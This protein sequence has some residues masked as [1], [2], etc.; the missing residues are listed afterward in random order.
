MIKIY[1][2]ILFLL[3]I[4]ATSLLATNTETEKLL[5]LSCLNNNMD[6]VKELIEKYGEDYT[7]KLYG[8]TILKMMVKNNN[9]NI[10]LVKLLISNKAD[11]NYQ[12]DEEHDTSLHIA[13]S[14]I[15][16]DLVKL[17][18]DNSAN[19]NKEVLQAYGMQ[20]DIEYSSSFP[21]DRV[22]EID[23]LPIHKKRDALEIIKYL[24]LKDGKYSEENY[25]EEELLIEDRQ[26]ILEDVKICDAI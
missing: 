18:I 20:E 14:H 16:V 26:H 1:T 22:L 10:D 5:K 4:S 23:P 6:I 12:P 13:C 11:V 24:L 7:P 9:I 2:E 3:M 19:V 21:L 17:L 25:N 15:N 8:K